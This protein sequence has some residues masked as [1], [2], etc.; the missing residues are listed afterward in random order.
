MFPFRSCPWR[1]NPVDRLLCQTH[2]GKPKKRG[3]PAQLT[4]EQKQARRRDRWRSKN[5]RRQKRDRDAAWQRQTIFGYFETLE[6]LHYNRLIEV[7]VHRRALAE[8]DV[9]IRTRI[10][11]AVDRLLC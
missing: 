10:D 9:H 6:V 1:R 2:G 8:K 7:L 3:R 5:A 11:E 4:P